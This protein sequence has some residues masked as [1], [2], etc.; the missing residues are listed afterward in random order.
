MTLKLLLNAGG[1][2]N[3]NKSVTQVNIDLSLSLS[4]VL[5]LPNGVLLNLV[6]FVVLQQLE[7]PSFL[8]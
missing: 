3:M 2:K 7:E 4:D 5:L 8:H 6:P 1:K